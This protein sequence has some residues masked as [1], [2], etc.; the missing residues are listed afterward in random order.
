MSRGQREYLN[1]RTWLYPSTQVSPDS[2]TGLSPWG[3]QSPPPLTPPASVSVPGTFCFFWNFS[4]VE[5]TSF[6]QLRIDLASGRCVQKRVTV[7]QFSGGIPAGS[8][9]VFTFIL[10]FSV[11]VFSPPFFTQGSLVIT[12]M[13]CHGRRGLRL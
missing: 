4:P 1:G 11:F 9:T 10:K 13:R 6:P 5:H 8:E 7:F 3:Q 2:L 12:R